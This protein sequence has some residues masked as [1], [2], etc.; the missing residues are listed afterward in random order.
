MV[1]IEKDKI[2]IEIQNEKPLEYLSY[3]Q[4]HMLT[5][6]ESAANH[7]PSYGSDYTEKITAAIEWCSEL[8]QHTQLNG[9]QMVMVQR[10]LEKNDLLN[11]FSNQ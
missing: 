4:H 9:D 5:L 11:Q 1:R 3:Y 2:I 8:L 10:F 7:L 6:L